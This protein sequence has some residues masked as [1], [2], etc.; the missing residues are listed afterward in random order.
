MSY[1]LKF[2][3]K[4]LDYY[5]YVFKQRPSDNL[6]MKNRYFFSINLNLEKNNLFLFG[7][8]FEKIQ[9]KIPTRINNI[10]QAFENISY[11]YCIEYKKMK[12]FPYL[13][14]ITYGNHHFFLN[15]IHNKIFANIIFDLEAGINK[16]DLYQFIWE[17]D[18]EIS[19]N[20]LDTHLTNLKNLIFK[21]FNF[22]I[23][24]KSNK[25]LLYL[26]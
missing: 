24:F 14:K 6:L 16:K 10:H 9:F 23:N 17:R 20:K 26:N 1:R 2:E 3:N 13:N 19:I 18:K 4:I 7:N 12:Y 11:L 15:E 25:N 21:N 5:F 22:L 8:H